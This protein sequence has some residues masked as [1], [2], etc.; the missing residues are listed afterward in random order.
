M[1]ARHRSMIVRSTS[2]TAAGLCARAS[3]TAWQAATTDGYW[4]ATTPFTGGIGASRTVAST[5]TASV[6]SDPTTI[7]HRSIEEASTKASRL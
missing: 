2:S 6:P 4:S 5:T 1:L 3:G 7:W